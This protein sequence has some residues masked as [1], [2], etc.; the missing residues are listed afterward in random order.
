MYEEELNMEAREG[1]GSVLYSVK[2][3]LNYCDWED[4]SIYSS[5]PV[6]SGAKDQN[7]V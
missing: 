4:G 6:S 1:D 2:R 5:I 3:S 7:F